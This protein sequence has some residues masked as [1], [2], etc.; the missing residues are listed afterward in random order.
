MMEA[1]P[2]AYFYPVVLPAP[3]RPLFGGSGGPG[4]YTWHLSVIDGGQPRRDGE[5]LETAV[6]PGQSA[7]DAV[8][9]QGVNLGQSQWIIA[10]TDG[11]V[12]QKIVFGVPG[13]IPVT[14]DWNGSGKA[15]VGVFLAGQWFLDLNGDGV[16]DEGDLWA[17]LGTL[18]DQPVTGDWDG[19]GKTDIGI[20]GPSWLGDG[21]ALDRE[22]G[23]PDAQNLLK[24][25]HK[26]I[27]PEPQDAPGHRTMKRTAHSPL[28][29]DVID[30]VFEFGTTGDRAVVG[31]WNGD[32][33]KSIGIFRDGKW[34][35]DLNG[36]GR[37]DPSDV[38]VEFGAP[39]DLPVVGDWSGDGISKIGVYRHGTFYLDSNNNRALDPGDKVIQ[40]G[41]PGDKPVAG[42]FN[43]DGADEVGVY[44]DNA[45]DAAPAAAASE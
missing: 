15:Q 8:A 30:H 22:P 26:N 18:G 44:Q 4:G 27:P 23:L 33:V 21:R 13:A 17:R 1:M 16:W 36:N 6:N 7:F 45:A 24:G 41:G 40:L 5:G 42:D 19:D 43:G 12:M 2:V 20:F 37:W 35:L 31:D 39:G 9:W 3:P 32:G 29:S 34:F 28:R 10:N 11:T 14:G 38:V 25:R